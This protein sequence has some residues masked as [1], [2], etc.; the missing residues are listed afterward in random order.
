[1]EPFACH[2]LIKGR[3]AIIEIQTAGKKI[4]QHVGL[5]DL[6]FIIAVTSQGPTTAGHIEQTYGKP[7]VYVE[8]SQ[9]ICVYKDSVL[10]LNANLPAR[11]LEV[12]RQRT[13]HTL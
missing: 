2:T 8:I 13:Q 11:S 12:A 5:G 9:D 7:E 6:T 4:A 10:A 1:L 3:P